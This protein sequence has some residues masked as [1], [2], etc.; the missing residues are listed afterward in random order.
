[1]AAGPGRMCLL[2]REMSSNQGQSG[3]VR[4]HSVKLVVSP[5]SPLCV[6]VCWTGVGHYIG[7]CHTRVSGAKV[8]CNSMSRPAF[9]IS[10][11]WTH[12]TV[13]C[14]QG[15]VITVIRAKMIIVDP[16]VISTSHRSFTCPYLLWW[17]WAINYGV[18]TARDRNPGNLMSLNVTKT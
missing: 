10:I 3:F 13:T 16:C 8:S 7:W 1:M 5:Q 12:L 2:W 11:I 17:S 4:F 6:K 9:Y 14:G 15:A 18:F